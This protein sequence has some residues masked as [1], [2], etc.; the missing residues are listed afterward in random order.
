MSGV[1]HALRHALARVLAAVAAAAAAAAAP[2][3]AEAAAVGAHVLHPRRHV[4]AVLDEQVDELP[5]DVA[6]LVA[7]ERHGEAGVAR[8]AGPADA[9]DVVRDLARQVEVDDM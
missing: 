6:V 9:V 3:A 7:E 4:L 5:H 8:A 2:A 1:A